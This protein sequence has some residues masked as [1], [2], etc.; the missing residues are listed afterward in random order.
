MATKHV[1]FLGVSRAQANALACI[2]RTLQIIYCILSLKRVAARFVARIELLVALGGSLSRA[3]YSLL[4]LFASKNVAR[5][6]F[7]AR[8][9][10]SL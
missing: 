2:W 3:H 5:V 4:G 10:K 6:N 1:C 9:A 7:T 8:S